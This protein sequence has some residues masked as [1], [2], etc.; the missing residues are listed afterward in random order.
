MNHRIV[1][2][3]GLLLSVILA[4]TSSA[5]T[6]EEVKAAILERYRVTLPGFF[7][8]FKE[9]GS[10]LTVRRDG[11]KSNRP[12]RIFSPN[13]IVNREVASAGGGNLPPGGNLD[14]NLR[15]GDNLHLYSVRTGDDFVDLDLFTTRTFVMTGVKGPTP[16]Q[17]TTRFRYQGGLA[18]VTT[19]QV[20][21][22]LDSWFR[23]EGQVTKVLWSGS[24]AEARPR[25]NPAASVTISL[26]QT[27]AEV[28][29]VFGEP[30]KKVLLGSKSVFV[31]RDL[32]VV[33]MDGKVADA[34]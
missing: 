33:F 29:A 20:L 4:G 3:A 19:K 30:E 14:G 24:G 12:S 7:G 25:G 21:E 9:I 23:S 27:V 31:Y 18:G 28:V 6:R 32:K 16:L 5:A 10:V 2:A 17:A 8:D 26:G 22:D 34:Y 15:I 11:L 13:I 1:I